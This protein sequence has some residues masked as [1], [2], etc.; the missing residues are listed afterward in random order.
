MY[1]FISLNKSRRCPFA[2]QES[3]TLNRS[4]FSTGKSTFLENGSSASI[5]V[6]SSNCPFGYFHLIPRV[7]PYI[8][9]MIHTSRG[10]DGTKCSIHLTMFSIQSSRV[11]H[12]RPRRPDVYCIF[13]LTRS[14][15][16][17]EHARADSKKGIRIYS[18]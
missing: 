1:H 10:I 5:D 14:R 3:K 17:Y 4:A 6:I 9:M 7:A 8:A 12:S 15:G 18:C 16:L 2:L 13:S 11:G